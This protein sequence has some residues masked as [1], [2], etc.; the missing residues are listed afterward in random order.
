MKKYAPTTAEFA[1]NIGLLLEI[2]M[3][4]YSITVGIGHHFPFHN[5]YRFLK[6]KNI[7]MK[8]KIRAYISMTSPIQYSNTCTIV[9]IT[10]N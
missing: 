1:K 5:V 4:R 2:L 10:V 3:F 6:H 9:H 8:Y 7:L